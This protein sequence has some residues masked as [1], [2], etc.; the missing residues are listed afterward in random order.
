[1]TLPAERRTV[2]SRLGPLASPQFALFWSAR[3]VSLIGDYTFRVAFIT[4]IITST[5]RSALSLAVANAVLLVPALVFYLFGGVLG[6]RVSSRRMVMIVS[7]LGRCAA[8]AA[9]TA[10]VVVHAPVPVIVACAVSISVGDGFFMPAAFAYLPEITPAD[11]LASANSAI[12]LS[13]QAGLIIGP[14]LGGL[15]VGFAGASVA[16]GFDA[17]SFLLSAVLVTLMSGA[18]AQSAQA[19]AQPAQ[20]A[21]EPM[22]GDAQAP[23]AGPDGGEGNDGSAQGL[24]GLFADIGGGVQYVRA[25]Q[26]LLISIAIGTL[27]NAVFAGN[28]D[29]TVPLIVSPH[30]VTGARALGLFYTLEGAGAV[31]GAIILARVSVQRAGRLLFSMLALMA[32]SLAMV[33][34]F[35]RSAGTFAMAITY[36]V[37]MHF[38]NTLYVTIIQQ[39]VPDSLLSRVSSL[40]LLAFQGLMPIGTLIMGPLIIAAG[41]R[42]TALIT[43]AVLA[44]LCALTTLVP[45]IG[46]VSLSTEPAN[47]N[48]E[49]V[50]S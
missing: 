25:Q 40:L 16:F 13:Q 38:F 28:L 37:G 45:S 21:A 22:A 18:A 46:A 33:G 30:G 44:A 23:A 3:T 12:S 29:V 5:H 7:D 9:I 15:L 8:A 11:R 4:Y 17:G 47:D 49:K 41:A 20:A 35:N 10:C 14:A 39:K 43:G 34:V 36:G 1:M 32:A 27:A 19:A 24:R 26:W 31:L 50:T 48:A 42:L 6:D 2:L